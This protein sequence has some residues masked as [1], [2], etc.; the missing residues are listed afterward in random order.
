MRIVAYDRGGE[1]GLGVAEEGLVIELALVAPELP[2]D[3][4]ALLRHDGG[5]EAV[6]RAVGRAR[7]MHRR[8]LEGLRYRLPIERH[9]KILCLGMNFA[10]T[11]AQWR[12]EVPEYPDLFMR[13]ATSLTPHEGPIM[14]PRVSE[15][16]DYEAELAV[17]IGRRARYASIAN[18]LDCVAG[19][20]CFNDGSVRDFQAPI[21]QRTIGKNFDATGAFGPW[22]VTA[23]EL[24][25]GANGLRIES[26]LC[27][28]PLQGATTSDMIVSVARAIT[29]LSECL[30]LEPGDL[31]TMGTPGGV[32]A[33]RH[34][35]IWMRPGDVVEVA[36][37]GIGVLRN[38][39]LCEREA[40]EGKERH[41]A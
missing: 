36:I 37:E 15:Q 41:A 2:S 13:G 23:D 35:R 30:T 10:A 18:A 31:I 1:P 20:A 29:L 14:R 16:L 25:P 7:T 33:T 26:Y 21:Q 27:G 32:G 22:M 6:R 5:L 4:C 24:P 39:V 34:P 38:P 40:A 8:P 17:V 19:Y 12:R 9:G 11:A 3:L 28:E